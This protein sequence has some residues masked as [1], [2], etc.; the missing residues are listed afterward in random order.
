VILLA[1]QHYGLLL[2]DNGSNWFFSGTEDAAW[3][4]SL[5]TEL[6]NVPAGQFDAVDESG[7]MVDPNSAAARSCGVAAADSSPLRSWWR[8]SPVRC[9]DRR[10]ATLGPIWPAVASAT[11]APRRL[12]TWWLR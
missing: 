2:A 3:P 10:P 7:M 9:S 11:L 6:K 1:M 12:A 4:D 8:I 5:L